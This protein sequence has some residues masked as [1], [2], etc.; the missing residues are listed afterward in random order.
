MPAPVKQAIP[1]KGFHFHSKKLPSLRPVFV[2]WFQVVKRLASNWRL[3]PE[4][5]VPYWY[6]E[7]PHVGMLAAAVWRTNGGLAFEEFTYSKGKPKP[8]KGR[9]DLWFKYAR[10]E[11]FVEAKYCKCLIGG[12]R[13]NAEILKELRSKLKEAEA[14][15]QRLERTRVCHKHLAVVFVSIEIPKS[16]HPQAVLRAW[17]DELLNARFDAYAWA[18][19]PNLTHQYDEKLFP[20]CAVLIKELV[21]ER[22]RR[23]PRKRRQAQ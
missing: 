7:R 12:A 20:G 9:C 6:F 10:C 13:S 1:L 18:F 23:I 14:C 11:Y 21:L 22:S 4:K 5:D 17:K 19:P 15:A 16:R 2:N 3:R 8:Y